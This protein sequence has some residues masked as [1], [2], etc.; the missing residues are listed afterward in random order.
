MTILGRD[1]L[2]AVMWQESGNDPNALGPVIKHGANA[3][4]RARSRMQVMKI[5]AERPGHGV[6]PA[7]DD[8]LDEYE[9]VGV[10]YLGAVAR[11]HICCP[12]QW[13]PRRLDP[14]LRYPRKPRCL[15]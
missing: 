15:S 12:S 10:D 2:G 9:R 11:P 13:L 3:G 8:S 14:R 7:K 6:T 5:T 1:L 4:D